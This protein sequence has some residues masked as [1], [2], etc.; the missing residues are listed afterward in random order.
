VKSNDFPRFD[1]HKNI[2]NIYPA[3]GVAKFAYFLTFCKFR[4][5]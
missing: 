1:L 3:C 4:K 5:I 2:V